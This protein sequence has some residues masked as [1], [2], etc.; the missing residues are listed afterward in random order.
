MR[1]LNAEH[2]L[3][4]QFLTSGA[5]AQRLLLMKASPRDVLKT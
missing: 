1:R 5:A 3:S 2:I 4:G